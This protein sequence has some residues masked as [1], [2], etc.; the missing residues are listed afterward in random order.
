MAPRIV[1]TSA[2]RLATG[3]VQVISPTMP[4]MNAIGPQQTPKMIKITMFVLKNPFMTPPFFAL[5]QSRSTGDGTAPRGAPGVKL[6]SLAQEHLQHVALGAR[7]DVG[8]DQLAVRRRGLG[9]GVHR[10]PHR[11]D[12]A[13]HER[14]HERVAD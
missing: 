3:S 1:T 13:A 7:D 14:R 12:V 11:A 8:A 6:S 4:R 2:L 5:G 10:R 9:A